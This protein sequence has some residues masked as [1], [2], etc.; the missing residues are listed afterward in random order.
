[1]TQKKQ[2]IYEIKK[3]LNMDPEYD[4]RK[5]EYIKSTPTPIVEFILFCFAAG[6]LDEDVNIEEAGVKDGLEYLDEFIDTGYN[7]TSIY[8][9]I[10]KPDALKYLSHIYPWD[11]AIEPQHKYVQYFN[12]Y[13]QSVGIFTFKELENE[14]NRNKSG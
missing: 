10:D 12:K 1:M 9:V 6:Y 2:R 11:Y 13:D 14:K 3:V 8:R 5:E 4:L 7:N